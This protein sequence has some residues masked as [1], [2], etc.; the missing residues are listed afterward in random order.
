MWRQFDF[1]SEMVNP[2]SRNGPR[3]PFVLGAWGFV[4]VP[5]GWRGADWAKVLGGA[6]A[7]TGG[8]P[9]ASLRHVYIYMYTHWPLS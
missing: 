4:P 1:R 2:K 6:A 9:A 8:A 3:F 5:L 7:G